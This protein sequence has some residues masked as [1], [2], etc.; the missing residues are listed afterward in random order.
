MIKISSRKFSMIHL[1]RTLEWMLDRIDWWNFY[2][3]YWYYYRDIKAIKEGEEPDWFWSALGGKTDY[4]SNKR[5][6]VIVS[7]AC[8]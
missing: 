6:Q 2:Y 8:M 5:L 7:S 3:Q 4:A 1:M